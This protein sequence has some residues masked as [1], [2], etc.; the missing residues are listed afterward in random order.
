MPLPFALNHIN[1]WLLED[2]EGWTIVDTGLGSNRTKEYWEQI[3]QTA[4]GGKPVTRVITTHFHPDHMGLAGWLVE[5]WG[6]EFC[7]S[8]SEW[9]FGRMLSLE[10]DERYL[11]TMD[12]FYR[13]AGLDDTALAVM[14]ERGNA[15]A[16]G[17]T[18][19][20]PTFRRLRDGDRLT[21]GGSTWEVI[22]GSGHTPEH[23]CLYD[24]V[25]GVLIAGDQILPRISPNISVWPSEPEADPLRDFL[26]SLERLNTLPEETLVLPS[27]DTPF[28]GL[29]DR[30]R[31][32]WIHH[33]QRL[34]ETWQ[35]CDRP[36]TVT[37]VTRIM[38]RRELD[39]HQLVFA[40][41]EALAHLNH[42]TAKGR[43]KRSLD[44]QGV[45]QFAQT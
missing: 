19:I 6:A 32:L 5:R 9:L 4:L 41:G 25:R 1:L 36:K 43:L 18:A 10:S 44:R 31:A 38:F 7:A 29:H 40:V 35:A 45:L 15:Y 20:P 21:I 17:V 30:V 3:F 27:H 2:D 14:A 33:E 24:P 16:R 12:A 37:E 13:R 42:L 34:A 8:Q 39:P 28:T 26:V 22:V 11:G 23:V